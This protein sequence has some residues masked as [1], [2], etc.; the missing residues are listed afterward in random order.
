MQK[1]VYSHLFG[2][3]GTETSLTGQID[4]VQERTIKV[5]QNQVC[6]KISLKVEDLQEAIECD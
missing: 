3:I 5:L 1:E 6:Q 2:M 4:D